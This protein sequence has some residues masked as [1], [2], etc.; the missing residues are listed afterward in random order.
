M[1]ESS[2]DQQCVPYKG[3]PEVAR[4]AFLTRGALLAGSAVAAIGL[5]TAMS[6]ELF[7]QSTPPVSLKQQMQ[8]VRRHENDHVAFLVSALGAAARP[9]PTF[10][11]EKLVTPNLYQF[12]LLS[13]ALENTGV[14]AYLGAAPVI[15]DRGYL[16]AAGSIATI[17]SRH[18]G[19]FNAIT[20]KAMTENVFGQELSFER[21]G[22]VDEIVGIAGPFVASLN[23]GPPLTFS[24]TPSAAND[25][26]ILNFALALEYLEAEY[27]NINVPKYYA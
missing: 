19:M 21:A 8:L 1:C 20:S 2:T 15:L 25:I 7:G 22:T 13:R 11:M 5:T 17:E 10:V 27:Y 4:R 23:G 9:K 16:A 24:S 26:A 18:A 3:T 12:L 6:Q 14:A